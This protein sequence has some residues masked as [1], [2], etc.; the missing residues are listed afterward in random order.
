MRSPA[1]SSTKIIGRAHTVLF[2]RNTVS[3]PIKKIEGHYVRGSRLSARHTQLTIRLIIA[4]RT[5]SFSF[6]RRRV[7]PTR[8]MA[9]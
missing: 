8:S 5:P 6:P 9:V 2:R 3:A 7:Y 1:D 4:S